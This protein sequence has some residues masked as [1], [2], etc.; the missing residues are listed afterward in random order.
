MQGILGI[1]SIEE[2]AGISLI[3]Q[4]FIVSPREC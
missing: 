1:I 2:E 3:T 4:K